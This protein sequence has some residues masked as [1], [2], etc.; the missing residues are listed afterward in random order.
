MNRTHIVDNL[1]QYDEVKSES[2]ADISGKANVSDRISEFEAIITP[3]GALSPTLKSEVKG[4]KSYLLM[5]ATHPDCFDEGDPTIWLQQYELIAKGNGW[6]DEMKSDKLLS[7]L[8]G[9]AEKWYIQSVRPDMAIPWAELKASLKAKFTNR[10]NQI[11]ASE[12]ISQRLQSKTETLEQYWFS[13]MELINALCPGMSDN[14]KMSKLITGMKQPLQS[15]LAEHVTLHP[16]RDTDE[17]YNLAKS[18]NDI[19]LLVNTDTSRRRVEFGI[20]RQTPK[21]ENESKLHN[22]EWIRTELATLA[23]TQNDLKSIMLNA[24]RYRKPNDN[25]W[26]PKRDNEREFKPKPNSGG[27]NRRRFEKRDL[28]KI[29]CYAC[30]QF[31]HY[32]SSCP[33]N[34]GRKRQSEE[35][36]NSR[37]QK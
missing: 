21:T 23:K 6:N 5:G 27:D 3:P 35:D 31:G 9:P 7:Y 10:C 19:S 17:L 12:R 30:E 13:K 8:K 2:N 28:S 33:S 4:K 14:E 36:L 18:Y 11:M 24:E 22:D 32:A 37:R 20:E 25:D 15:K 16:C 26:K 34:S 29:K 1:N